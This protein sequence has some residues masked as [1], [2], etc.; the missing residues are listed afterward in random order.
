MGT[1]LRLRELR[2]IDSG[3]V[4][5]PAASV[6]LLPSSWPRAALLTL[7]GALA[8]AQIGIAATVAEG[9]RGRRG[10]TPARVSDLVRLDELWLRLRNLERGFAAGAFLFAV[11]WSFVAVS[12]VRRAGRSQR[13][14]VV[15]AASWLLAPAALVAANGYG[16]ADRPDGWRWAAVAVPVVLLALPFHLLGRGAVSLSGERTPFQRWYFISGAAFVFHQ[17]GTRTM[18]LVSADPDE[19]GRMALLALVTGVFLAVG[20]LLAGDATRSLHA[21]VTSR[22]ERHRLSEENA[23]LRFRL[24]RP[25]R[26]TAA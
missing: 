20:V 15:V 18:D 5:E 11:V 13:Y 25:V 16:I 22:A 2:P 8:C 4:Q 17:V 1:D 6:R 19:L 24:H 14:P 23:A 9:W 12:N 10:A 3:T 7:I 26:S 21:A